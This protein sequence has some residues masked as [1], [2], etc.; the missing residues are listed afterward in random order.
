MRPSGLVPPGRFC[1][2]MGRLRAMLAQSHSPVPLTAAFVSVT[3]QPT[4]ERLTIKSQGPKQ[5]FREKFQGGENWYSKQEHPL[6]DTR[7]V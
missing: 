2:L 3:R 5:N 6:S 1:V 7:S 4:P